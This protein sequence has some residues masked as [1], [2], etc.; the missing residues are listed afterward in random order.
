MGS[1]CC[2]RIL[3][4]RGIGLGQTTELV[5]HVRSALW[6]S[7]T[8]NTGIQ[9]WPASWTPRPGRE[10]Y[11]IWICAIQR[12]GSRS[13]LWTARIAT[14]EPGIRHTHLTT[15]HSGNAH[16]TLGG[17]RRGNKVAD[18]RGR[19]SGRS[20]LECGRHAHIACGT[21]WH[22]GDGYYRHAASRIDSRYTERSEFPHR[23]GHWDHVSYPPPT[24]LAHRCRQPP[25]T[26][27]RGIW[28]AK[29]W[30]CN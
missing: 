26:I 9:R 25:R 11:G 20:D 27:E 6:N 30:L 14:I 12:A 3:E 1:R 21:K 4:S 7:R 24:G 17:I 10:I 19:I 18:T 22:F 2:R 13:Q 23:C 28:S 5:W 29:K 15:Q 8:G 16:T